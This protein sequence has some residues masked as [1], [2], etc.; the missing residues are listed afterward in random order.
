MTFQFNPLKTNNTSDESKPKV[1]YNEVNAHVIE[2]AG[3][4]TKARSIPGYI[5]SIVDLGVQPRTIETEVKPG[6]EY[7]EDAEYYT[8]QWGD[9]KGKPCVRFTVPAKQ[10]I[11][12]TVDFPQIMVDKG[13]FFG[14]S[15]E[16]PLRLILNGERLVQNDEG[17]WQPQVQ[18]LI[19]LSEKKHED[20]TWAVAKNALLHNLAAAAGI[21]DAQGYFNVNRIGELLG[22]CLQFQFRVY[23]KPG[24]NGKSY[25]TEEIKLAGIVPEGVSV[26]AMPEGVVNGIVW[27]DGTLPDADDVSKLRL[28]IR[29]TIRNATNFKGSTIE[30][31][32]EAKASP[33]AQPT[34]SLD[35]PREQTDNARPEPMKPA[36]PKAAVTKP[37][38][39]KAVSWE[40]EPE[41]VDSPFG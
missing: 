29:N 24:K 1:D 35:K 27:S 15:H 34:A 21:L 9:Q 18:K 12:I 32:I 14:D 37:A 28:S 41:D 17:K 26:P 4:A 6:E 33:S 36:H 30:P 8:G 39:A 10:A 20:G 11:A 23:M 2:R 25:Y 5:S 13:Q 16:L 7:P 31:L 3:T 19:Y 40:D 38:P 22:Q